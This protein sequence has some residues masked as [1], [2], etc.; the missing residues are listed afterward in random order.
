MS[1][2][3][4]GSTIPPFKAV[5]GE[6]TQWLE[7]AERVITDA[8]SA[9]FNAVKFLATLEFDGRGLAPFEA[10]LNRLTEI[11]AIEN[12]QATYWTFSLCDQSQVIDGHNRLI[13]I[14]TGR[15]LISEFALRD[16]DADWLLY[17]DSDLTISTNSVSALKEMNH[18]IVGGDVPSYCLGGRVLGEEYP[19]FP[20]QAHWNTA[21]FLMVAREIFQRVQWRAEVHPGSRGITDDPTFATDV[22]D[23]FGYE[24]YVRK[25]IVG[26]HKPL[27]RLEKRG[28]DLAL[29][30]QTF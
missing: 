6:A 25:D 23:L 26:K 3:V 18:P 4:I 27:V 10:V 22:R 1:T 20:V 19:T 12:V 8:H 2:L 29:Y 14:C 9:G 17:L 5:S 13:R 30:D 15:N 24:T 28:H 21:G 11:D 7:G 16:A